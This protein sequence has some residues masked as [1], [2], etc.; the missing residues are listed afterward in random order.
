MPFKLIDNVWHVSLNLYKFEFVS[1]YTTVGTPIRR[2]AN[3]LEI[4]N[5]YDGSWVEG[6]ELW[7]K[8]WNSYYLYYYWTRFENI[9]QFKYIQYMSSEDFKRFTSDIRNFQNEIKWL[10]SLL[11]DL[12]S[13]RL[14]EGSYA[15]IKYIID[16]IRRWSFNDDWYPLPGYEKPIK[17]RAYKPELMSKDIYK[18]IKLRHVDLDKAT[19]NNYVRQNQRSL[20]SYLAYSNPQPKRRGRPPKTRYYHID[21]YGF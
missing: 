18:N 11:S 6:L 14:N 17:I 7:S 8:V 20:Q 10:Q 13:Y 21:L 15:N 5:K 3:L 16:Y 1:H 4:F 12:K 19:R 2:Q 9:D